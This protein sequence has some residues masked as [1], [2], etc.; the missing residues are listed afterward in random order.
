RDWRKRIDHSPKDARRL[1][2]MESNQRRISFRMKKRG[3]HWSKDVAEALVKVKQGILNG[4]LRK[5]YLAAERRSNRKQRKLKRSVLMS[6]Y[7]NYGDDSSSEVKQASIRLNG[8]HSSPL[9]RLVKGF[10]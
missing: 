8:A 9:G 1:G 3:M 6:Y 7:L 10:R 5:V 4:T 2:A